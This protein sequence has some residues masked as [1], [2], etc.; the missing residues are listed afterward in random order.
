VRH[1]KIAA[2]VRTAR[3]VFDSD[4]II[5]SAFDLGS[6]PALEQLELGGDA[7]EFE[8]L[9]ESVC[10]V[11]HRSPLESQR[12]R[13]LALRG[14]CSN[15]D[16]VM[17]QARLL[18]TH[19]E[20]SPLSALECLDLSAVV[21][22]LAVASDTEAEDPAVAVST[23]AERK[24]AADFYAQ[25]RAA[26]PP[27]IAQILLPTVPVT[28]RPLTEAEV[29]SRRRHAAHQRHTRMRLPRP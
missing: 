21:F 13:R 23:A 7:T 25:L 17:A 18:R 12:L 16:S 20:T 27:Q 1:L 5:Q 9:L 4:A 14:V 26:L 6:W 29:A 10:D 15:M 22:R 8:H 19:F 3:S 2:G 11:W 28:M 24:R